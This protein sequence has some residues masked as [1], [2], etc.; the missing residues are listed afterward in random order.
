MAGGLADQLRVGDMT[1]GAGA[2]TAVVALG[3]P[4][5]FGLM[6]GI[7]LGEG[8]GET[9]GV[10]PNRGLFLQASEVES[11]VFPLREA[12]LGE[13]HGP[14]DSEIAT[15]RNDEPAEQG[16]SSAPAAYEY[17]FDLAQGLTAFNLLALPGDPNIQTTIIPPD[18]VGYHPH[19][20][21]R[22]CRTV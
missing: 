14:E 21:T 15:C 7:A 11:L 12:I 13:S 10:E 9:C 18:G 6:E 5:D 4:D 3:P 20:S 16:D 1:S 8:G 2:A 22:P 17:P 19:R